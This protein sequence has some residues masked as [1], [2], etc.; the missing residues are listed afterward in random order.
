MRHKEWL[1]GQVAGRQ[2]KEHRAFM[3]LTGEAGDTGGCLRVSRAYKHLE[4]TAVSPERE[5]QVRIL[6]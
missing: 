6:E 1:L 3:E 5:E 2:C 4:E